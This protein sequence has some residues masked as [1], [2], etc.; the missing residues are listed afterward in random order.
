MI[1]GQSQTQWQKPT[2]PESLDDD[3]DPRLPNTPQQH[4]GVD[5]GFITSNDEAADSDIDAD[6]RPDG[7]K[8]TP[9]MGGDSDDGSRSNRGNGGSFPAARRPSF[10]PSFVPGLDGTVPI[11]Q[12]P[13]AV[14]AVHY[15][16]FGLQSTGDYSGCERVPAEE[17]ARPGH[18]GPGIAVGQRKS[19]ALRAR[20]E[21]QSSVLLCQPHVH[22]DFNHF[23]GNSHQKLYEK[24]ENLKIRQYST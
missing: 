15:T 3:D 18:D 6:D 17:D 19:T 10:P 9:R 12:I 11:E 20:I 7:P 22:F 1:L 14:R 8:L 2:V 13:Y 5:D 23:A 21:S 16:S 4:P 24:I